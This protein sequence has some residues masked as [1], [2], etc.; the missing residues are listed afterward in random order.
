MCSFLCHM[1]NK[2][3]VL[4]QFHYYNIQGEV[5][6]VFGNWAVSTNGDVVNSVYPYAIISIHLMEKD[7]IAEVKNKVWFRSECETDLMHALDRAKRIKKVS[8]NHDL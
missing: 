3:K 2:I 8:T 6:S 1:D 7:W 4:E 5:D